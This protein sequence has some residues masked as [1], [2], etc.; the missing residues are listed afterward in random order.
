MIHIFLW[1]YTDAVNG[2][3]RFTAAMWAVFST[4]LGRLC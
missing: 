3:I 2:L 1:I 4:R